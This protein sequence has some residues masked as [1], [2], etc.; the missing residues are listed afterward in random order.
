[1]WSPLIGYTQ[2][3]WPSLRRM[4]SLLFDPNIGLIPNVPFI[5]AAG[6]I[7]MASR[8]TPRSDRAMRDRL[9]AAAACALLLAAFAQSVNVNHGATPSLNRWTL[10]LTPWLL[11]IVARRNQRPRVVMVLAVLN[12]IWAGWFFRP[13]VPEVYRYPTATA[14]WLW[15]HAP[16]WY[17]P[18]AEVF[19]ERVSHRE[20]AY[21]PVALPG[22]ATVLIIDGRWPA[23]CP[24]VAPAPDACLGPNRLCYA[25]SAGTFTPLGDASFPWLPA[26]DSIRSSR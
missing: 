11:L 23:A 15:S 21:L 3:A 1:M 13:S 26:D 18:A 6:V 24:P 4:L 22:C 10:W 20:P 8:T 7:A 19:A 12:T 5:A 14:S 16:H 25:T 2:P 17:L 9:I